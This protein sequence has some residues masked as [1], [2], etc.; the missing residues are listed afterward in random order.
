MHEEEIHFWIL[1]LKQSGMVL[2][3]LTLVNLTQ[4]SI[5]TMLT[6]LDMWTRYE[7]GRSRHSR[8]IDRKR[9]WHI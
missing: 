1:L 7:E 4:I 5:V 6:R 8:V 9:F 3:H 2:E